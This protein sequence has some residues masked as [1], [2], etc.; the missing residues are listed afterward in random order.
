MY[1]IYT[2]YTRIYGE[3][4]IVTMRYYLHPFRRFRK[5][6]ASWMDNLAFP[7]VGI[8]STEWNRQRIDRGIEAMNDEETCSIGVKYVYHLD[9][10][11]VQGEF[12]LEDN[13]G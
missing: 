6:Q 10:G 4:I 9:E 3:R 12:I 7:S 11:E 5:L 1:I 13:L 8:Q 2:I